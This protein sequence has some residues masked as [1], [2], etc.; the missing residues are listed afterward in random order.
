MNI[1]DIYPNILQAPVEIRLSRAK[2]EDTPAEK[3]EILSKDSF[4]FVRDYVATNKNTPEH[5]LKNLLNDPVSRVRYDAER[6]LEKRQER[7]TKHSLKDKIEEAESQKE[8][9]TSRGRE[10]SCHRQ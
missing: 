7:E 3:L 2:A 5:C 9:E 8:P 10:L 1:F 6:T 4:W